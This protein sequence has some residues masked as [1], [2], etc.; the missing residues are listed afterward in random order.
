M[1]IDFVGIQRRSHRTAKM[2]DHPDSY[3][4][5]PSEVC[6]ADCADALIRLQSAQ[7]QKNVAQAKLQPFIS[8]LTMW[9]YAHEFSL[10]LATSQSCP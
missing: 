8:T 6:A 1:E 5:M 3:S 4:V 7:I 2:Q 10:S 9:I